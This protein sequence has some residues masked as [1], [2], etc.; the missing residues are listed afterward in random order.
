MGPGIALLSSGEI[1]QAGAGP[2]AGR[3]VGG[4]VKEGERGS[5]GKTSN[6]R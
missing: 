2:M 5:I 3:K 4:P 1:M 6:R